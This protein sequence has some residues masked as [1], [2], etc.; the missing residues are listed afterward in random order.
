LGQALVQVLNALSQA[1][2]ASSVAAEERQE[3]CDAWQLVIQLDLEE[4]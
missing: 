3:V 4:S 1:D 2:L